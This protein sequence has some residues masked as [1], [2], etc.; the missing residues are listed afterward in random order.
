MQSIFGLVWVA[1][2]N[3]QGLYFWKVRQNTR[4]TRK[5][6]P[7][8]KKRRKN[9]IVRWL[10]QQK[11]NIR[12]LQIFFW[13]QCNR[14]WALL[15]IIGWASGPNTPNEALSCR[16]DWRHATLCIMRNNDG[17]TENERDYHSVAATSLGL[18]RVLIT[19]LC[20]LAV[21]AFVYLITAKLP[22]ITNAS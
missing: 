22:T 12:S 1:P 2:S 7:R 11:P 21:W 14:K 8:E 6:I 10:A 16:Y 9:G 13:S 17:A 3:M 15:L 5:N 18:C 4:R 19:C 20:S